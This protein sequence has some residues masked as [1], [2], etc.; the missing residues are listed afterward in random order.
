MDGNTSPPHKKFKNKSNKLYNWNSS[1]YIMLLNS[2]MIVTKGGDVKLKVKGTANLINYTLFYVWK[3]W[4][5]DILRIYLS[6]Y[7]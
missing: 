2:L 3:L 7:P 5:A 4:I 6:I 1:C